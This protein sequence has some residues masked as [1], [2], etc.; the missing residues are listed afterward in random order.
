MMKTRYCILLVL[1][2]LIVAV[3]S[4]FANNITVENV[5]LTD[6]DARGYDE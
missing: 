4:S 2:F 1:F 5:S 6:K 3:N